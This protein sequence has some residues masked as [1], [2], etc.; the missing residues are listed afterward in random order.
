MKNSFPCFCITSLGEKKVLTLVKK[1]SPRPHKR[2]YLHQTGKH[3][4][5][6]K[7]RCYKTGG[8]V[9][10]EEEKQI[11]LN[12][13]QQAVVKSGDILGSFDLLWLIRWSYFLPHSLSFLPKKE[14][15]HLFR[16]NVETGFSVF[17]LAKVNIPIGSHECSNWLV[18]KKLP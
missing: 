6:D 14:S 8:G 16:W 17:K 11:S 4:S 9:L 7:H 12:I 10:I 3:A 13:R 15:Y 1:L 2:S 18:K 5:Q